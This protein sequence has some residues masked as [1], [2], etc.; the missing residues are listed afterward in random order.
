MAIYRLKPAERTAIWGGR[1]LIEEFGKEFDGENLAETW[2]LSA[3]P[4][5]PCIIRSGEKKGMSFTEL[6]ESEGRR[7][8]GKN[9]EA[10]EDFPNLIK[11]IDA[12]MDLSVQVHPDDE[13][14]LLH[15]NQ[16]GKTEMWYVLKSEPGARLCLGLKNE[17]TKEEFRRHVEEKT[18]GDVLNLVPV[19]PGD[20]FL[21]EAGTIHSIGGGILLVE[22]Q[23]NSNVTYRVYDY[24][25]KDANGKERELH[26][27]KALDV[28]KLEPPRMDYDFGGH[29]GK[30]SSFITDYINI[31]EGTKREGFAGEDSFV[32]ILFLDGEGEI[33]CGGEALLA[34]KGECFFIEANSGKYSI[35]G[36]LSALEVR[37][38]ER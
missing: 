34:K 15:E 13:Y 17:M 14:A 7:I 9:C 16:Y 12:K 28:A 24:G 20:V 29:I 6:I 33:E 4:D 22:I 25:R 26:I 1:K 35:K 38:P 32:C 36:Q 21:I 11:L 3:H 31:E 30:S 5:G 10:Y 27:D 8:L 37:I 19:K 2:E 18:L 23:Q